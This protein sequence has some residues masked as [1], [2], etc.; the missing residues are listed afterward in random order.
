MERQP[1]DLLTLQNTL[2]KGIESTV[3]EKVWLRAEISAL[4]WRAGG[5]C[6][7]ELSQSEGN[8]LVAKAQANI[9][10][11]K[12]S[13]LGPYFEKETGMPLQDG[14]TVLLLVQVNYSPIY[15]LSLNVDDIDPKYTLG[16]MER[17]RRE[18]KE[19]LEKDGLMG[20][21]KK[22]PAVEL[23]RRIAVISASDAAGFGDFMKHL[24]ENPYGFTFN[25]RL[26]PALMQGVGCPDSII[27]AFEDILL[28]GSEA[29]TVATGG[30]GDGAEAG[31]DDGASP[32]GG[33]EDFD[34][35]FIMRGGG[36]E[37]DLS[38]YDDYELCAGIARFPLPVFTAIGH[39]KDYHIADMVAYDFAKTP[40]ALADMLVDWYAAEDERLSGY[41]SRLRL[42]FN[43]K[44]S[45]M[46]SG[47]ARLETR[48]SAALKTKFSL[49]EN[50]VTTMG[51]RIRMAIR[52]KL[53]SMEGRLNVLETKIR[54]ADPRKILKKGYIL[55]LDANGL[56]IKSVSGRKKGDEIS[57]MFNDGKLQCTVD[58]VT[59][60]ENPALKV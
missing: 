1:I 23:P 9:W 35:V 5:H 48:L 36:S 52:T 20:L 31:A 60:S 47:V 50:R 2:K 24:R 28:A 30:A 7:M 44:I 4:K 8:K 27:S 42:A 13:Y 41:S 12:F 54:E 43:S 17:V 34:A 55:A 29:E 15:G 46:E 40:T 56:T 57:L 25:V 45:A 32:E 14:I 58:E 22:L 38:C 18:T 37:L 26:F 21:Q 10:A 6:Y 16:E 49:M 39:E 51:N 3:P 33:T 59:P 53:T 11:N 19:R